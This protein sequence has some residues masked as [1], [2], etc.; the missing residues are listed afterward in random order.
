MKTPPC[1][2]MRL[3]TLLSHG[4]KCGCSS[5]KFSPLNALCANASLEKSENGAC[6]HLRPLGRDA[7]LLA[8]RQGSVLMMLSGCQLDDIRAQERHATM[9]IGAVQRSERKTP[10]MRSLVECGKDPEAGRRRC[11][12]GRIRPLLWQHAAIGEGNLSFIICSEAVVR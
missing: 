4:K 8:G 5:T 1:R 12:S 2:R 7:T 10:Q 11:C 6:A 9:V 3:L